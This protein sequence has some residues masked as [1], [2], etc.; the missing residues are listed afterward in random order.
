MVID[1]LELMGVKVQQ[2]Q[3]NLE[4]EANLNLSYVSSL[5]IYHVFPTEY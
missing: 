2:E 5:I 4:L 1:A 3:Y